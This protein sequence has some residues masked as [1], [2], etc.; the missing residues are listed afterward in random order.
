[1][2]PSSHSSRGR[3]AIGSSWPSRASSRGRQSAAAACRCRCDPRRLGADAGIRTGSEAPRPSFPATRQGLRAHK[4]GGCRRGGDRRRSCR[5][6]PVP[7]SPRAA[8]EVSSRCP[9][10]CSPSPSSARPREPG[11]SRSGAPARGGEGARPR[12]TSF[13]TA[14]ESP[15]TSTCRGKRT[16]RPT[17]SVPPGSTTGPA[18]RTAR[19]RQRRRCDRAC[20]PVGGDASSRLESAPGVKD[21]VK[22]RAY[23]AAARER[24]R[25]S[26]SVTGAGAMSPRP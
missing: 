8:L 10:P 1:M 25:L 17:G 15:L 23:V 11:R 26:H 2:P 18:R 21:H 9:I 20:P 5:F 22:M 7:E 19:R 14:S 4:R 3:P 6:L 24:Q 16:I 12:R 13:A